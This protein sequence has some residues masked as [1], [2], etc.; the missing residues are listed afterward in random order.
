MFLSSCSEFIF[1]V[2]FARLLAP[3]NIP[4]FRNMNIEV[5]DAVLQL[6]VGIS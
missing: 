3:P 6:L 5:F 2:L 4:L 1:L